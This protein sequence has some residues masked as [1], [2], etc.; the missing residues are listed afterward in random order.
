ML[1]RKRERL[2]EKSQ[3]KKVERDEWKIEREVRGVRWREKMRRRKRNNDQR[4][5]E[6]E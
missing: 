3:E 4:E 2:V 5:R 1:E 6:K